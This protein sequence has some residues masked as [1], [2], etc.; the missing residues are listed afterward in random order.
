MEKMGLPIRKEDRIYTYAD[1][2]TWPDEE[3][4]ELIDGVAYNM[5]PAPNRRHQEIVGKV[6][7]ELANFLDNGPCSVYFAPFDVRLTDTPGAPD[8]EIRNVVQPD[9]S[10]Y[11]RQQDQLDDA[12]AVA[13]PDIAVE[14]LSP[15]TS[16][17]DQREKLRLYEHF[18]VK[19]Y[20]IIDPANNTLSVH[21]LSHGAYGKPAVYGPE[22]T[23]K[24]MVIEG[25]TLNL[26]GLFE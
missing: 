11:C 23:L 22:E 14:V 18:G 6:F 4:W 3:R 8:E 16:V 1:Y 13:A 15:S 2:L 7:I 5:S 25:F 17:K 19:E 12:G 9:V 26:A 20:W 10:I 21:I 24:S